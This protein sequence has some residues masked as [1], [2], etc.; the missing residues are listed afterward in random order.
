MCKFEIRGNNEAGRE[1]PSPLPLQNQCMAM[2][3]Q[4]EGI[5]ECATQGCAASG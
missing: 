2:D 1:A 5:P 3:Q 4:P